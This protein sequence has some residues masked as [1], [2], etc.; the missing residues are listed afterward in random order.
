[1]KKLDFPINRCSIDLTE[2]CNLKCEYCHVAGTSVL[3]PDFTTIKIENLDIGDDVLGF[4][5]REKNK[6][7]KLIKTKVKG[8]SKRLSPIIT[9]ITD[10]G[11]TRCTP[12]H[13][14]F[15]G[16]YYVPAKVG[17]TIRYL[18]N[19]VLT[20]DKSLDYKRG[21]LSGMYAGDG[22]PKKYNYGN[23]IHYRCRLV[24]K[25]L[26]AI[27]QAVQF[28]KEIGFTQHPFCFEG[29]NA[30]RNNTKEFFDFL[31]ST[32]DTTEFKRGWVA[33]FFDAEG[34]YNNVIRIAQSENSS[35]SLLCTYLKELG[36][37]YK[38]EHYKDC[39][40]VRIEGGVP[41]YIRFFAF[42]DTCLKRKTEMLSQKSL[43]NSTYIKE[44]ILERD[45]DF[46]Y[47]ITTGTGNYIAEGMA[48][49]NCFTYGVGKRDLT[50]NQGV[51]IIDWLFRDEVSQSNEIEINW[52]G[53]EP[54]IKFNLMRNL[55][56]YAVKKAQKE[57][58]RLTVGGTS[59]G[60]LW[61][62]EVVDWMD[63]TRAYFLISIDGIKEVQD[64][65]RPTINGGSSYDAILKY[66]PYTL[67]K[68]P[69]IRS[70]MAPTPDTVDKLFES[71]KFYYDMGITTQMFSPVF[72][73]DW[74][75]EALKKAKEN[76]MNLSDF[77]I[78]TQKRGKPLNITHLDNNAKSLY[79]HK[80]ER[81]FPCGA[82]RF[83]VGF[84]VDGLIYPCHRFNKYNSRLSDNSI[85]S[86]S[87]GITKPHI[88][89]GFINFLDC[90]PDKCKD[91]RWYGNL[92]DVSCYS[93][94]FDFTGSIFTPP[95]VYCKWMNVLGESSQ[96]Y[97]NQLIH[98]KLPIK[99]T[100]MNKSCICN[101]MCYL[102]GTPNEIKTIDRSTDH[103][104]ICYNTMYSGGRDDQSR[105]LSLQPADNE[106]QKLTQSVNEL[107]QLL[108]EKL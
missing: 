86:I 100:N 106:I 39:K 103:S 58:K 104:C 66:L 12:D 18:F 47:N 3:L 8:I 73:Y 93:I 56:E 38:L 28:S 46:V 31:V 50:F 78:E 68:I 35:L 69:F 11:T 99:G 97:Y 23:R 67:Q 53:G 61:S 95:D 65:Y 33:G 7:C 79:M 75:E 14:W 85:G 45:E 43:S 17:G 48:S 19:N 49:K 63:K 37:F 90:V 27:D 2:R 105:I 101:N 10:K 88:R 102:E 60:T 51:K 41:E 64:K 9:I 92:C 70:R 54:F 55:T 80:E 34:S 108:R 87:E 40:G 16:R 83:Y 26:E 22:T 36:F 89:N 42:F 32:L 52:W 24:L 6:F 5:K 71:I 96:Y 1:M 98:N 59:N 62:K 20:P 44:I 77:M 74:T 81:Q 4:E 94:S 15:N 84:G 25:D 72:E 13:R 107:I 30:I 29:L 57:K 76:L 21:W 91:C 82:G